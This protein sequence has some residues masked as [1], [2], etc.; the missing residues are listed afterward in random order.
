[1]HVNGAWPQ[2]VEARMLSVAYRGVNL[3][4]V[5]ARRDIAVIAFTTPASA[6][7]QAQ[8]RLDLCV[9]DQPDGVTLGEQLPK[10]AALL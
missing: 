8:H 9:I 7:Q 1:M 2:A 10:I 4:E 6:V 3:M 5:K